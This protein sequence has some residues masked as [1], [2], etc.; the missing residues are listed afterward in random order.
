MVLC[1]LSRAGL[2]AKKVRALRGTLIRTA[3]AAPDHAALVIRV[4][5]PAGQVSEV[6][7]VTS[8]STSSGP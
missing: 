4:P 5:V 8:A 6:I 3:G 7:C 1:A 2:S